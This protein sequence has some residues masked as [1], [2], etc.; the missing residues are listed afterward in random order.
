[1]A[2]LS[3]NFWHSERKC[4][5]G[6]GYEVDR[7]ELVARLESVRK[8]FSGFQGHEAPLVINSWCR[9]KKHNE[10]EGGVDSSSHTN[11]WAVDIRCGASRTRFNLRKA[12]VLA[13]FTRIGTGKTFLHADMD[14]T[15]PEEVEWVYS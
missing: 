5:C 3:A 10:R 14:P 13:G 4:K 1:M 9:C 11:G 12:L 15:K 7:P 8:Y 6:C 2:D